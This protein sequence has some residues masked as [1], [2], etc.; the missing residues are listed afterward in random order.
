MDNTTEQND[1]IEFIKDNPCKDSF[2]NEHWRITSQEGDDNSIDLAYYW[3]NMYEL[4]LTTQTP[5]Q[6]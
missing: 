2:V 1:A 4:S 5:T 3:Q 6:P